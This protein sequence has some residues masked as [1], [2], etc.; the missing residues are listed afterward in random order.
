[1]V[2]KFTLASILKDSNYGL[3][4]FTE[5]EIEKL[6]RIE[7]LYA[8]PDKHP[9]DYEGVLTPILKGNIFRWLCPSLNQAERCSKSAIL[10]PATEYL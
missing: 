3:S 9:D 7:Y 6:N 10:R 8:W 5:A 2:G 1:M 4:I